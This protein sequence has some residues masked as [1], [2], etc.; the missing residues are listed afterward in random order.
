MGKK[1]VIAGILLIL[2][3]GFI[4]YT[5]LLCREPR[6]YR[7]YNFQLFWSYQRFFDDI[8]PLGKQIVCNILFFIPF[9]VLVSLCVNGSRKQQL[10]FTV[11]SACLLSGTVE[12]LQFILKLGFA[13]FDDV[14]DN[15]LGAAIGAVLVLILMKLK[16]KEMSHKQ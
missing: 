16:G 4:I 14:F 13:E 11:I 2:Y 9:G 15:T 5:T 8:E 12:F 3:I 10:V 7:E 6:D 1:R